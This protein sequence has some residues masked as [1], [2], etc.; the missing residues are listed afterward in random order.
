MDKITKNE[1]RNFDFKIKQLKD[2]LKT[3]R[4]ILACLGS[5]GLTF[6]SDIDRFKGYLEKVGEWGLLTIINNNRSLT[7]DELKAI[8]EDW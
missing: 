6:T 5:V 1:K 8:N 2:E 4:H 7:P 3:D